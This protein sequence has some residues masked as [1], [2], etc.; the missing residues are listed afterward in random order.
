MRSLRWLALGGI[1]AAIFVSAFVTPRSVSAIPAWTRGYGVDCSSCHV[2]GFK[3]TRMGQDF[4]RSGHRMPEY[5][6]DMSLSDHFSVAQKIRY[7]YATSEDK[8]GGNKKKTNS[9]EQ[10]ALS[11]YMGGPLQENWSYFAELYW[12]ENSGNTSG[13]SDLNDYGRTKLA[14]A[15]LQYLKRQNEN[16]FTSVRFGQF[17]PY[18]LHLHGVGARLSQDRAY[19][20]NSGT[21]GDNPYKPFTRQ[22][23]LELSQYYQG[24]NVAA[25]VMNGT[26]GKLFNRVDNDLKKDVYGAAD[27]TFDGNGSMLGVY[28]YVGHYPLGL[29]NATRYPAQSYDEF[30][31][32]GV[33]GNYTRKEGAI[34]GSFFS[35]NN[36]YT[37]RKDFAAPAD[38]ADAKTEIKSMG[39]YVELQIY[40]LHPRVQP[41]L[42]YDFWDPDTDVDDNEALGP[43]IGL[44]WRALDHGRLVA[45]FQQLKKKNTNPDKENTENKFTLEANFMY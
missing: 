22:Y 15:Y 16:S 41:Y 25:A 29:D 9:F 1:A 12:H 28:G 35:N 37:L 31:Q 26:G 23:G 30:N 38:T 42:R 39:Y 36:E 7:N 10:H 3:L 44:S 6:Q 45:Q 19:V 5:K 4:L 21:V 34:V 8:D 18:L 32:L 33:L 20:I 27:Y 43:M 24:F 2:A 14:D 11:L 17:T 13:S 40:T